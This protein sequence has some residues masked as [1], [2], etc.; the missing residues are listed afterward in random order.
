MTTNTK[1]TPFLRHYHSELLG[2][3]ATF[4]PKGRKREKLWQDSGPLTHCTHLV[5]V[6]KYA[7]KVK[8]VEEV[9]AEERIETMDGKR[10]S[11]ET[12]QIFSSQFPKDSLK[13]CFIFEKP[14]N[15]SMA[16]FHFESC[17]FRTYNRVNKLAMN[18]PKH[19][20]LWATGLPSK[21]IKLKMSRLLSDRECVGNRRGRCF[22]SLILLPLPASVTLTSWFIKLRCLW[23]GQN[24]GCSKSMRY[25]LFC[26]QRSPTVVTMPSSVWLR[27]S[28]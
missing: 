12:W 17:Q 9:R 27:C 15:T 16:R 19:E 22:F 18:R 14:N 20:K 5:C 3:R 28:L 25:S 8:E 4:T 2:S 11:G 24:I 23:E 6:E 1:T 7:E 10:D 13:R 21:V 26:C